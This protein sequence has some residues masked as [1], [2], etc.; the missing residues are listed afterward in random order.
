MSSVRRDQLEDKT[1]HLQLQ[2]EDSFA[3]WVRDMAN[4]KGNAAKDS[5]FLEHLSEA[6]LQHQT[7]RED[8]ERRSVGTSGAGTS[9]QADS[10]KEVDLDLAHLQ[11]TGI[12][13]HTPGPD[14]EPAG[15]EEERL[16]SQQLETR[17]WGSAEAAVD[18]LDRSSDSNPESMV[19]ALPQARGLRDR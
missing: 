9:G 2:R 1:P 4:D 5:N 8:Q 15:Q 14:L 18:K 17:H 12:Q 19:Y 3:L 6:H 7:A 13:H 16:A 11:E 10:V